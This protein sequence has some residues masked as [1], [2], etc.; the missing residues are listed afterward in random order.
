MVRFGN[1]IANLNGALLVVTLLCSGFAVQAQAPSNDDCSNAV[2]I[3]FGTSNFGTGLFISDTFNLSNATIQGGELFH[4]SMVSSGNDDKSIW[5]KFY[6]P[7][8]RGIKIEL[9][10]PGNSIISTDVGFTTYKSGNCFPPL[11]AV[12]AAYIT[13]LSQF[14]SSFHPCME[15]GEY[16]VQVSSKNRANGIVQL[17]ITVS[18]PDEHAS[19]SNSAY[20]R[21]DS[22]YHF[23]V[24]EKQEK[25]I[26]FETGCYSIEDTSEWCSSID[27]AYQRYVQSSWHTFTTN[28]R[29]DV[30][31]VLFGPAPAQTF[32]KGTVIGY[33]LYKGDVTKTAF[34]SLKRIDS[35]ER[36]YF[37][38]LVNTFNDPLVKTY[39]CQLDPSS[40]YS[41]QLLY[42]DDFAQKVRLSVRAVTADSSVRAPVPVRSAMHASNLL[43]ALKVADTTNVRYVN[44]YFSCESRLSLP[45]NQCGQVNRSSG[46]QYGLFKYGL[47]TWFEFELAEA[48]NVEIAFPFD[49]LNSPC[50]KFLIG[51]IFDDTITNNC[52][53]LDT[54]RLLSWFTEQ[55][56][57][58]LPCLQAGKYAIQILGIDE[59]SYSYCDA[60]RHLGRN[61]QLE[62]KTIRGRPEHKF[63]LK[64]SQAVDSFN[65]GNGQLLPLKLGQTYSSTRDTLG[66][67]RSILPSLGVCGQNTSKG[68]YRMF[69]IGDADNDNVPDSGM[70]LVKQYSALPPMELDYRLYK[71]NAADL[72]S[73][74][75]ISSYPDTISGLW[76]LTDC[77]SADLTVNT[78][79]YCLTPG[80]YTLAT[81]G[82]DQ[83]VGAHDAP[84]ISFEKTV[85]K[86]KS[87]NTPER[88]DTL[89]STMASQLDHFSCYDNPATIDGMAPC[90][91]STKLIYRQFYLTKS[92]FINIFLTN[93]HQ[94]TFSLFRGKATD[95]LNT[96]KVY[97]D[98]SGAW[99]C[100]TNK[101]STDCDPLPAGW[102]TLVAYSN[103]PSYDSTQSQFGTK[104]NIGAPNSAVFF[105]LPEPPRPKYNRPQKAY[106]A[107]SLL[108]N[109]KPLDFANNRGTSASPDYKKKYI[110]AAENFDCYPDTPFALHPITPCDTIFNRSAYYV[111]SVSKP[112]HIK[113]SGI[114]ASHRLRVYDFDARKTPALLNSRQPIQQ[115][116]RDPRFT[117]ICM[118][119]SGVYTLVIFAGDIHLGKTVQPII[120]VDSVGYSRFDFAKNAYDFGQIIGDSAFKAGKLGDVHPVDPS[121]PPS[122]DKFYCTTGAGVSDPF[123]SCNGSYN[124]GVYSSHKNNALWNSDTTT[125]NVIRR[126]IWY[127]FTLKGTG[128]A[129]IRLNNLTQ[130]LSYIAPFAVYASDIKAS[131]PF[132]TLRKHGGIDST[133][134]DGLIEVARN[135]TNNCNN[136]YTASFKKELCDTF[137]ER[138]YYI[139]LG[140][141]AQN[142]FK[143]VDPIAQYS[144][145][146]LYDSVALPPLRFDHYAEANRING[147]NE[148]APPYTNVSLAEGAVYE[149]YPGTFKGAGKSPSDQSPSC[150]SSNL[151]Y[152]FNVDT[153][154]KIYMT[155]KV[156]DDSTLALRNSGDSVLQLMRSLVPGDS[157]ANGLQ[158]VPWKAAYDAATNAYWAKA[159][160]EPG[161][162]YLQMNNCALACSDIITPVIRFDYDL[163]DQCG[164]PA[165][166]ILGAGKQANGTVVVDCHT[167]GEGFGENGSNMGCL[168]G[169]A[170]YKSSWFKVEYTDTFKVDL[171]FQLL[172]NTNV[173]ASDIRYRV[174]YGGCSYLS[175][176]PCNSSS[177]TQFE[178]KCMQQGTYFVQVV[179]PENALGTIQ[180]RVS[181][182]QSKDTICIPINPFKPFANFDYEISCK[183]N[184]VIFDNQSSQGDSIVYQWDFGYNN[185]KDTAFNPV[186][187][188]PMLNSPRAY[189]VQLI[190]TNLARNTADTLV[191]SINAWHK[192]DAWL[193]K[194][195]TV[196]PGQFVQVSGKPLGA[197]GVI[198][199][200]QDTSSSRS[201]NLPGIYKVAALIDTCRFYDSI[202]I[203]NFMP[204][205]LD[206]GAD[207]EICDED[208]ARI[209]AADTFASYQWNTSATD[210]FIIVSNAGTYDL[211][212]TDYNGCKTSDTINLKVNALPDAS[213][214][215]AGPFCVSDAAEMLRP[216]SNSGG[217]FSGGSFVSSTGSFDPGVANDG[218]HKV[219]YT[220]TDAKNC[221]STDSMMIR[222]HPL[223]NASV[224]A[225]G[226]LCANGNAINLV[227]RVNPGGLFS[228]GSMLSSGGKFD[229]V[230]AGAGLHKIYY[231]FTDTNGC[232]NTDSTLVR[233]HPIPNASIES[234]GPL[235]R[236]NSAI[237]LKPVVNNGGTFRG[238]SYVNSGGVFQPQTAGPGLHKIWYAFTDSNACSNVDSMV[239]RVHDLPDASVNP[240]PAVCEDLDRLLLQPTT[241]IGGLFYG[242][243]YIDSSGTFF[244]QKSGPGQFK[245]YYRFTDANG[246]T[247]I[248][249]SWQKVN[250]LPDA[251]LQALGPFCIDAGDYYVLPAVNSGGHFFGAE[252][253][254]STGLFY[255]AKAGAGLHQ[256]FYR[257]TD[258]NSCTSLDSLNIR[259]N[260]LPDAGIQSSGPWCVDAGQTILKPTTNTGGRFF[261]GSYIQSGGAFDPQVADSGIHRVYYEFT[262]NN[263][264]Y[265]IDSTDIRVNALP[266]ASI[267]KA[268]PY[269]VDHLPVQLKAQI[270]G[271]GV[272]S[273]G[274][275]ISSGG[276]FSPSL[277]DSG[278]HMVRYSF[279]DA[280]GC[281]NED[282]T[283][284]RVNPLPD[285]SILP[286][287]PWCSDAGTR[288]IEAKVN[289]GGRFYG[290]SYIDGSGSFEPAIS[291]MG[292]HKVWYEFTDPNGCYNFD[293]IEIT[294]NALPDP[295]ISPAGPWCISAGVMR[296]LPRSNI[297]GR[298]FGGLYID[299]AGNFD[300]RLAGVG[301]HKVHYEITDN[302]A[303]YSRDSIF[304]RVHALPDARIQPA[305]PY[306]QDDQALNLVPVSNAGGIF[307]G[308]NHV[309]SSGLFDPSL[310]GDGVHSIYYAFTDLNGCNNT[311]SIQIRVHPLPDPGF[312]ADLTEG[313]TVLP[314][315]FTGPDGM[316]Q[317]RW[318]FSNGETG[319]SRVVTIGFSTGQWTASLRVRDNNGCENE[320]VRNNYITVYPLPV[321]FFDFS[322]KEIYIRE[323]KVDFS[324]QSRGSVVQ[325]HWSMGDG[326]TYS[327]PNPVHTYG[328]TGSYQ[329]QLEVTDDK[330]CID[331]YENEVQVKGEYILSIPNA[332][333]PDGDGIN[334]IFRARGYGVVS[335]E[336]SIYNRWG[337]LL[338]Q[339]Q[340][341]NVNSDGW[342]GT[343]KGV[344][345]PMGAYLYQMKVV[346][347]NRSKHFYSGTIQLI[348]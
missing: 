183:D 63:S 106:F 292:R 211:E 267:N 273:G 272:F 198:W 26:D 317:Y 31:E 213:M 151:W 291:G 246:C 253:I 212:V 95:G 283:F 65:A 205:T 13:P 230:V 12:S 287:G 101:R 239:I 333:S 85:T 221:T 133:L 92:S 250:P 200:D 144:I 187:I 2:G 110:L 299:D 164:T 268:G 137:Y 204:P 23:G 194:D 114:A 335:I 301:L 147:L 336:Y 4:A 177:L 340:V 73:Q 252:Y 192:P 203:R 30:L 195:T 71:G 29:V 265:N 238:G 269:C 210:S 236:D 75:N 36:F 50:N 337:E 271:G 35:C 196:C 42:R 80:T 328:D 32:N 228:G 234:A 326:S 325:W 5:F 56:P 334:E 136:T 103:G 162:Y 243:T 235:C 206:L 117:E 96:L 20:D 278:N 233:V 262:D 161:T 132:D 83:H 14:G 3:P 231:D 304:V 169:P 122:A 77:F 284:I 259:V 49:T 153:T 51:R 88:L 313:C 199:Y 208:R 91:I 94:G 298:F 160:V 139:Q 69:N 123:M 288:I 79:A 48:A 310:A 134:A 270:N 175:V 112:S 1:L 331:I 174:L 305:G 343:Y 150:A 127:T 146:V 145:E 120:T 316:Q 159:C 324:N 28:Y 256:I 329:V 201:F 296:V 115:C 307:S 258:S 176:G 257:Y 223:P 281:R 332:F 55:D 173:Q 9:K 82:G 339:K 344:K 180:L 66:C 27:T 149:G 143:A 178:L 300:T 254:D 6:L 45:S 111:F 89:K 285:A 190:V 118:L 7:T 21:P 16:L 290:G 165:D 338:Y 81:F 315:S 72:R 341:S 43:G 311:D 163:G 240:S 102:Y 78:K 342:D 119:D 37:D 282:S 294:V 220:F 189:N 97:R 280:N 155:Y 76:P 224:I 84:Q 124:A 184:R 108:N 22:A 222:V 172:E 74:Q 52:N 251:S 330:G 142:I 302:N 40:T 314:V 67:L 166:I 167:I 263:G 289:K 18:Y 131:I 68:I 297:G 39:V 105:F 320:M 274:N 261:G 312:T 113:I 277:A 53:D 70:L 227:P 279:V 170:G 93:G 19:V 319:N 62:I 225:A 41:I 229:P 216:A 38:R 255:T 219:Y 276:T 64:N 25:F 138:R 197:R 293:S 348:R 86:Y 141:F 158:R 241:N 244:P 140:L 107:D 33:N 34:G 249:S 10:Q 100:F 188:Y 226:P 129:T 90:L 179:S 217:V 121:L 168:F 116:Y 303:C 181:A 322:P 191:K 54:L 135:Y 58:L 126:N 327:I 152:Q 104:G 247:N 323:P 24:I 109:G 309:N 156:N 260:A 218:L 57:A 157:T 60:G 99:T 248:D 207:I 275:Y 171:L 266:D 17:E 61:L 130:G 128:N 59:A 245:L 125:A 186:Y 306:C 148:S 46:L 215:K 321:S 98:Q 193:N 185:A 264:C 286:S 47:S 318:Q 347:L 202:V 44:D 232:S 209:T 214:V 308:G 87:P 182:V 154:G 346:D 11:S 8:K 345:V 242:G 295:S 237:Q 15:P